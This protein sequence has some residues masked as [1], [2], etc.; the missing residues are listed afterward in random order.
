MMNLTPDAE[1]Q[2]SGYI[3]SVRAALK[4]DGASDLA[5][6]TAVSALEEHVLIKATEHPNGAIDAATLK[7]VLEG[8][9]PPA[10]FADVSPTDDSTPH[11]ARLRA[12]K[13]LITPV[14]AVTSALFVFVAVFAPVFLLGLDAPYDDPAGGGILVFGSIIALSAGIASFG[15]RLGKFGAYAGSAILVIVSFIAVVQG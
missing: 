8:I 4:H 15:E 10:A 3:S 1:R 9:D 13:N 7:R 6:D 2:L 11:G 5:I 14:L 12:P